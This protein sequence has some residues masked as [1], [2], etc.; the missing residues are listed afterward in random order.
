MVRAVSFWTT[1]VCVWWRWS[2][3][4]GDLEFTGPSAVADGGN[5]CGDWRRHSLRYL[6][7]TLFGYP[8]E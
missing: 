6:I 7:N 1:S 8:L 4:A 5:L 2:P 3:A